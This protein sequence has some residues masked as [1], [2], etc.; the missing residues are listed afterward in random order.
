MKITIIGAGSTGYA[1]AAD[2]STAG[3][4][5]T[6]YEEPE[7]DFRLDVAREKGGVEF[8]WPGNRGFA[9]IKKATT[10][11]EDALGDAD[12]II[13]A[14]VA[15]RHERIALLC[16]PHLKKNQT[17]IISQGG[18]G[19]L[20]FSRVLGEQPEGLIISE[21]EGNFYSCR[22]A[23]STVEIALVP[24]RRYIAAF[25]AV[26]TEIVINRCRDIFTFDP[27]AN[28]LETALNS[29]NLVVHLAG[30]LLNTGAIEN[31]KGAF[32]LFGEGLSP[33]V[34][35]CMRAIYE[36]KL[37]L[38]EKLSYRDR[39]NWNFLERIMNPKEHPE[40]DKFRLLDGPNDMNHRYVTEDASTG[41]VLL[42]SLGELLGVSTP[43]SRALVQLASTIKGV[44]YFKRGRNVH[45]LGIDRRSRDELNAYLQAG[46]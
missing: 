9:G 12:L 19:S 31:A 44:D 8:I 6:L 46:R 39:F 2:L 36:E 22:L 35:R 43:V 38:F 18:A 45:N 7:Y 41:L 27:A 3:L 33:S 23:G 1:L 14:A 32:Y 26:N 10:D 20:I 17:I 34:L 21:L 28:V 4:D 16:S 13:V 24:R 25:P 5:V 30:S 11:I 40:Y 37:A 29:P 15:G 42:S